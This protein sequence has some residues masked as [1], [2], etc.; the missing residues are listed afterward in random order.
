[1]KR[2]ILFY[3]ALWLSCLIGIPEGKAQLTF[4]S[5]HKLQQGNWAQDNSNSI[6]ALLKKLELTHRTSFVYQK[7]LLENKTFTGTV[8][9]NDRLEQVLDR[10]LTPANLRFRKLK[11][12]GY[13]ILPRKSAKNVPPETELLKTSANQS[14][15]PEADKVLVTNTLAARMD[16]QSLSTTKPAD[17]VIR[18]KVT[19]TE[20]GEP[21]PG[22]SIVIKGAA[23]GTNTDASG[24][25]TIAV[26]DQN[27]V[28]VFSFVGFD[29]QEVLVGNQ[30]QINIALKPD[31][32]ELNEVVVVGFGTQK[33]ATVTG[34]IAA[35]GTKDLLQ[36]PVANISNSLV[37]RMPGLFA[38]QTSGEPGNNAS[39]LRIRGVSTFSG[40]SDPLILVNGV[41]VSNYNNIDPNEI[42][43]LTI[44]KDASATAIYGIR[45]AN[46]VLLITT[47]RGK[48]GK[49]QLSYTGNV[50]VTSFTSLRKG[51]NSYDYARLYNESLKNDTYV[52]GA[53]YV[54]K[55]TD[56]DLA[57]YKSGED[58]IF[59][60]NT[61][62]YSLVL[63]PQALQ[64]QHNLSINGGTEKVRYFVSAGFFSQGGQFN[65]SDLVKDFDANRKYKRYNFRSSFD[66]DVTKRLK[67]SI[68]LSSQTENLSGNNWPTVRVIEGIARANPL[69]SP[70][71]I[72]DKLVNL[73]GVGT[74]NNPL[75]DMFGQGYNRQF[76]NFLQGSIRLDYTLDFITQGLMATGIVN[77][78]NNNTETLVNNRTLIT[79]NAIRLP[80]NSVNL[81][82]QSADSPFSFG[83]TIG[84]TRRTYA[85]FGFD[86]KRAFGDHYVTALVNYNQ[87]KYFDPTLAFLVPNG[88]QGVVG[89]ATYG[90]KGRYLAEFT[91]GYNG[92]EN[93]APGN[94]F[95][96]FPAYSLGWVAS[97]ESFFP[98]NDVV[99]YLKIRGSYG[100]VGNDKIGSDRFLYRPSAYVITTA[101]GTGGYYF[102]E[103]GSTSTRYNY[104]SEGKLGNPN[105]TWERAVKQ[106]LG[107]EMSFWKGKIGLTADV[108]SEQRNNI[109]ANLGTVPV[110]VG[111]TL[112]AYNLGRMKNHGFDADI[113]YNDHIGNVN[114]WIKG[115]FTFARNTVEFQDEI[116]RPFSYQYRTGQ[117]YGQFFG[118]V[119]E[120]L[121]NTWAE[122]NDAN[123]P[124]SSWN[125][126]RLQPGDIK[127][128]DTNG[129]GIINDDDQ[130]PIGYS[131]FPEKIFGIS[132]GGNY[133][134]FDISVLFQGAGNVSLAY[135]RRQIRGFF[136]NSGA[137]EY[138]VNSWSAD[139]Y[140][141]GLPIQF[142]RLTQGDENN[143]NNRFSTYWVRDASY[144]RLKNVEIGY[145]IPKTFLAKL[146]LSGTR[147]YANAN[148]LITWSSVLP[149]VDPELSGTAPGSTTQGVT[150]EEPYPL[151]RTIN[152]GLNLKF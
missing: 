18:G 104:S 106:N 131:N 114:F 141:K 30:T 12:G 92:T 142:P 44:L 51:M 132:F 122:V 127:Y 147:V 81:V 146:G 94:R 82:P 8:N 120:G 62:W 63:K 34:A 128:K 143:H 24:L 13:T 77:Y 91:F 50:A 45:G 72:G 121:Y 93:F 10:V 46:G 2:R 11:G 75:A 123:R 107:V 151:T 17:I 101:S 76:K 52:S 36:S 85:Q 6:I 55:F 38:V 95:G 152:F 20:K 49:P 86:Y 137:P 140:E 102:G 130:V 115:N 37:G 39:T 78:Q 48:V 150:N 103:V 35:I 112:P 90:Y 56:A 42:E 73:V 138:L 16:L 31:M 21:V 144:V 134:G 59:H 25:Y 60:P 118:L 83:Q 61:D 32:K 9:E 113:T 1:M 148:N 96:F 125:N 111:A 53:V 116:K 84:K 119:A 109:L 26:P 33:K 58:P 98:K 129:D 3:T 57:L 22:A 110:T 145:N 135:N 88:Y 19:D 133:K 87:T 69:T 97:D 41:E 139:R 70:G 79:Y 29:K 66:F 28:L 67:A 126:N 7:E 64:T 136:E 74:A 99:T 71:L 54:P 5:V 43:N 117:R 149:G 89:R 65:H 105:V 68:D 27:A 47:K 80:D 108:F 40:A 15:E 4:A 23:K 100:E 14:T 124:V